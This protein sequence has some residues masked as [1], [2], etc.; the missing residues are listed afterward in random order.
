VICI[1]H[2]KLLL[3]VRKSPVANKAIWTNTYLVRISV[4]KRAMRLTLVINIDD[5]DEDEDEDEDDVL[6]QE[7]R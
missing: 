2:L 3:S 1:H 7:Y 6:G 4:K 5:E